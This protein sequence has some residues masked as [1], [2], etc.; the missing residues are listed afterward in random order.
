MVRNYKHKTAQ[1]DSSQIESAAKLVEEGN[2]KM[3][4]REAAKTYGIDRMT[5][6]RYMEKGKVDGTQ[7]RSEAKL[8]FTK[9]QEN[10][11]AGHVKSL[12]DRFYG[13][14]IEQVCGLA[15]EYGVANGLSIPPSWSRDK[16]AGRSGHLNRRFEIC[17]LAM[18]NIIGHSNMHLLFCVHTC[19]NT[20][21]RLG[22]QRM[23]CCIHIFYVHVDV[24]ICTCIHRP[25][26]F[27]R[28]RLVCCLQKK[29]WTL[30]A[31]A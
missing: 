7:R 22:K 2:G 10:E 20:K 18:L 4:I 16:K 14:T 31:T 5:L 6:K 30:C 1:A 19:Y 8:V 12:D 3:S 17:W 13:L 24:C 26:F 28:T 15:F 25:M 29:K 9:E 11:L 21:W 27:N 23:S